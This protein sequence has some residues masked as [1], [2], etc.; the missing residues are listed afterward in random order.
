MDLICPRCAEPWELDSLHDAEDPEQE[1]QLL[2]FQEAWKI[3]ST[4]GC[5]VLFNGRQCTQVRDD[6]TA[7]ANALIDL[8][9]DDVDGIACE[10]E[11]LGLT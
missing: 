2:P 5:G 10:L 11:D 4:K 6:R 9:G 8:L 7:A 1:G 3:F